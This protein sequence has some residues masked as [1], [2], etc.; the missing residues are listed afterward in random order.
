M[1]TVLCKLQTTTS[2]SKD[3]AAE[4]AHQL[5]ADGATTLL[6]YCSQESQYQGRNSYMRLHF[7]QDKSP[8]LVHCS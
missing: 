2:T 8:Y 7:N 5:K 3:K 1:E 6:A 4:Y